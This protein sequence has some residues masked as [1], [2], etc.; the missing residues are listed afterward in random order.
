MSLGRSSQRLGGGPG[1]ERHA[2]LEAP[3]TTGTRDQIY[4]AAHSSWTQPNSFFVTLV[5]SA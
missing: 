1:A 2:S 3:R 5:P 4:T